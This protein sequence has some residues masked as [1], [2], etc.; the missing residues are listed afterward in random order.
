MGPLP[1]QGKTSV[2][3]LSVLSRACCSGQAT[4]L[5]PGFL[6]PNVGISHAW[7][8]GCPVAMEVLFWSEREANKTKVVA[9]SLAELS[10]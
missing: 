6:L 7:E 8:L 2:V 4:Q 5:H 9:Q 3:T 1:H 10:Y